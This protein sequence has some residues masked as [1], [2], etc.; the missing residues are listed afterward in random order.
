MIAW[1]FINNIDDYNDHNDTAVD[2]EKKHLL[3]KI[4]Y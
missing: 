2:Y 4:I 1:L 3:V